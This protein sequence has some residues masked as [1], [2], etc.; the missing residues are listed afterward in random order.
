MKVFK[1]WAVVLAIFLFFVAVL[2]CGKG[3]DSRKVDLDK[4]ASDISRL[5]KTTD[6]KK[7]LTF[8]FDRRLH[9]SEVDH[10]E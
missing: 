3:E 5:V 1:N 9:P 4:R 2:S 8:C 10:I 7:S 6:M